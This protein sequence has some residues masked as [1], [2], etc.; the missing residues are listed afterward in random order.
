MLT[1]TEAGGEHFSVITVR[2]A[3]KKAVG[4]SARTERIGIFR[5]GICTGRILVEN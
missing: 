4:F 1:R 3:R 2:V 5:E